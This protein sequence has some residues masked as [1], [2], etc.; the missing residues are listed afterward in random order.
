MDGGYASRKFWLTVLAMALIVG[1]FIST[2]WLTS[3]AVQLTVA[4][5]GILGA[6]GL[7]VGANVSAD[8]V[9]KTSAVR[10]ASQVPPGPASQVAV[11]YALNQAPI[12]QPN[13]EDADES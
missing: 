2:A 7:Y 4:I 1:C 11:A 8:W 5:G 10:A 13:P 9:H 6:L 12:E 3:L